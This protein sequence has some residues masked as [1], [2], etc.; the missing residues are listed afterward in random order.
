[1]PTCTSGEGGQHPRRAGDQPACRGWSGG[2]HIQEVALQEGREMGDLCGQNRGRADPE[3]PSPG[4]WQHTVL[5]PT[6]LGAARA[7]Q[8]RGG[9]CHCHCAGS[10][11]SEAAGPAHGRSGSGALQGHIVASN[12]SPQRGGCWRPA[13]QWLTTSSAGW[14]NSYGSRSASLWLAVRGS[15]QKWC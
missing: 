5:C 1:M 8:G 7:C 3:Q 9:R 13:Q 14:N 4:L 11:S 15:P 12:Q 6:C 10:A 2:H